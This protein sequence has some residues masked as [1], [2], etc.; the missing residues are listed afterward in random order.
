MASQSSFSEVVSQLM[1]MNETTRDHAITKMLSRIEPEQQPLFKRKLL[2]RIGNQF[3]A[4][5]QTKL[6]K[7]TDI[8]SIFFNPNQII[9]GLLRLPSY[10]RDDAVDWFIDAYGHQNDQLKALL[11]SM[12]RD[13]SF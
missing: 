7:G 1:D 8:R 10:V 11:K 13:V 4:E 12:W 3:M 9:G 6:A 2:E 5:W